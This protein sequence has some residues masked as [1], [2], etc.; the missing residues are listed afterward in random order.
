MGYFLSM[1]GV[2]DYLQSPM[3]TYDTLVMD[4]KVYGMKPNTQIYFDARDGFSWGYT[5]LRANSDITERMSDGTML[6]TINGGTLEPTNSTNYVPL[7]ERVVLK[8][9]FSTVNTD[10]THIFT[11]KLLNV[12]THGALYDVKFYNGTTLVAHYDMRTGTVQDQSGNGNH[13][14][15]VG[16]TW[17][18]L[19]PK[20]LYM[21]GVDDT[22]SAPSSP[23]NKVEMELLVYPPADSGQ[24]VIWSDG[25]LLI[26]IKSSG[27][28]TPSN[29]KITI[30][31]N[32]SAGVRDTLLF[33]LDLPEDS[34]KFFYSIYGW[35]AKGNLYN[36][37]LYNGETLVAHYDMSTGMVLDQSGNENH[38][39]LTGGTWVDETVEP[40]PSAPSV[41][42]L[43]SSRDTIS[44]ESGADISTVTFSFDTDVI[45]WT[46]N[47]SGTSPET[48]IV[49]DYGGS[50]V[51][52]NNIVATIDWTELEQEGPNRINIY[53]M[54]AN[55]D[56]TPYEN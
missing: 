21:D 11:S 36:A 37:K 44:D 40:T 15:L 35:H 22:L 2:D 41:S 54:N 52:G 23:Y 6:Q 34:S 50:V 19:I 53:G 33:T 4:F 31:K 3:I 7:N 16:G 42:S 17:H 27:A 56:W 8:T 39:T 24:D 30:I 9:V 43:S 14:T 32:A 5:Q 48:G 10:D 55:G 13:A 45:Q 26:S 51:A 46:V 38:A 12:F 20:H 1:D 28:I 47:V 49:A 25:G 18:N 29:S